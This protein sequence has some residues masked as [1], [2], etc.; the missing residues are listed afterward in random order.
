MGKNKGMN[1]L[2]KLRKELRLTQNGLMEIT[3]VSTT[4]I[5]N[6]ET[7][8]IEMNAGIKQI[9]TGALKLYD[10]WYEQSDFSRSVDISAAEQNIIEYINKNIDS[11]LG[12]RRIYLAFK[13][14]LDTTGMEAEDRIKYIKYMYPIIQD[15]RKIAEEMKLQMKK[16]PVNIRLD[17]AKKI[18]YDVNNY[19][20]YG[21]KL[22]GLA[23]TP[24][25]NPFIVGDEEFLF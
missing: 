11:E 6:I 21:I 22:S 1:P 14:V 13:E 5:S 4:T 19:E 17:H 15:I 2:K 25:I 18:A 10:D 24:T 20:R 9:I 23:T 12:A 3:G 7:G 16:E 8:K